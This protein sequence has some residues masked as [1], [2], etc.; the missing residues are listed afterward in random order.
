MSVMEADM[1]VVMNDGQITGVGTHDELMKTNTEY[2][3]I[4]ASQMESKEKEA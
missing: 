4:Y 1:I 2:Q 3:E